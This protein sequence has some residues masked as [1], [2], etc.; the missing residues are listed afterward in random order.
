MG[1]LIVHGIDPGPRFMTSGSMPYAVFAGILLTQACLLV[2]GISVAKYFSKIVFIPNAV[3][4]PVIVTLCFLGCYA[5]RAALFDVGLMI[6]FGLVG[7][8]S[9]RAK[10]PVVSMLLGFLLGPL[11]EVNFYR[12]LRVGL[13]SYSIFVTRPITMAFL[14]VTL[15]FMSW[16]FISSLLKRKKG[17]EMTSPEAP[18]SEESIPSSPLA[19]FSLLILVLLF[20]VLILWGSLEY[21]RDTGMFPKMVSILGLG[22][23]IYH[24]V[25]LIPR[26]TAFRRK[27]ERCTVANTC[28][29]PWLS[30]SG[31]A[32]YL[33]LFFLLGF[34]ASTALYTAGAGWM[35]GFRRVKVLVPVSVGVGICLYILAWGLNIPLPEWNLLQYIW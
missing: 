3:L 25:I 2:T 26:I 35:A 15:A 10:Y 6:L 21:K 29:P 22:L 14:L 1:A 11:V 13:G 12:S 34:P 8:L 18:E 19:E 9:E 17:R 24:L 7:F 4:A 16:P 27:G 23:G 20:F 30:F 31:F 33:L 28:V 5:E 32:T